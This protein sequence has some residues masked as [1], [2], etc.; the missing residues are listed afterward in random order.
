[1]CLVSRLEVGVHSWCM[2]PCR[3]WGV[4]QE[5]HRVSGAPDKPKKSSS[6]RG[7]EYNRGGVAITG[8]GGTIII[9]EHTRVGTGFHCTVLVTAHCPAPKTGGGILR[10]VPSALASTVPGITGCSYHMRPDG[11]RRY[12][13]LRAHPCAAQRCQPRLVRRPPGSPRP[14]RVTTRLNPTRAMSRAPKGEAVLGVTP[15]QYPLVKVIKPKNPMGRSQRGNKRRKTHGQVWQNQ[16]VHNLLQAE[17]KIMETQGQVQQ[18]Q[19]R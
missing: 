10:I 12:P 9:H 15:S 5:V 3:D 17:E 18:N 6:S 14:E 7:Q 8:Y 19:S 1:M 13:Y 11:L 2:G 16:S 4:R